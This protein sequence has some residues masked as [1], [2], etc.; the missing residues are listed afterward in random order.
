MF[1]CL[2]ISEEKSA[3]FYLDVNGANIFSSGEIRDLQ[4]SY[5]LSEDFVN[6]F[7]SNWSLNTSKTRYRYVYLRFSRLFSG[8][9]DGKSFVFELSRKKCDES[10]SGSAREKIGISRKRGVIHLCGNVNIVT[11]ADDDFSPLVSSF[12]Y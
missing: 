8:C 1:S 10:I 4:P 5:F 3:N 12:R 9:A 11:L 2:L 6:T 7:A